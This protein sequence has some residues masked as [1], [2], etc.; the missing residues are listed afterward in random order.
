MAVAPEPGG[1]RDT[2]HE[3]SEPCHRQNADESYGSFRNTLSATATPDMSESLS[4]AMG[5]HTATAVRSSSNTKLALVAFAV[6]LLVVFVVLLMRYGYP[7][8]EHRGDVATSSVCDRE[9]CHEYSQLLRA[10]LAGSVNPCHN[11]YTYVC[12][13]VQ[14]GKSILSLTRERVTDALL[15][16]WLRANDTSTEK[17]LW[18]GRLLRMCVVQ[19][20]SG[21]DSSLEELQRFMLEL[22]LTWPRVDD[23]A[24][25]DTLGTLVKLSLFWN[26][27]VWF[28]MRIL[29]VNASTRRPTFGFGRSESY[30]EWDAKRKLIL[31]KSAYTSFLQPYIHAFGVNEVDQVKNVANKLSEIEEEISDILVAPRNWVRQSGPRG[32]RVSEMQPDD[33]NCYV[34][35]WTAAVAGAFNASIKYFADDVVMVKNASLLYRVNMLLELNA[36][37]V[38]ACALAIGWSVVRDLGSFLHASLSQA[39][40]ITSTNV[41][42]RCIHR[43]H[44]VSSCLTSYKEHRNSPK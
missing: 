11:F 14:G 15:D 21:G 9:S 30:V 31:K 23:N 18:A 42:Q 32:L 12:Q 28:S 13:G 8:P 7:K 4:D 6:A 39:Y 26:V 25:L 40:G 29:H 38:N 34:C 37:R 10:S 5:D 2:S 41:A 20:Q 43:L 22:N 36:D 16:E 44:Q 33:S 19:H 17:S 1:H 27:D 35:D 3:M 24:Y